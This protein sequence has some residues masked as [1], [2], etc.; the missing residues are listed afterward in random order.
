MK[1]VLA[2]IRMNKMNETKRA[3][4]DAGVACLT[5]RRALG[6]GKGIVDRRVLAGASDGRE[7]AIAQLG[8]APR[9]IPKRAI[10]V[11]VPDEKVET[12]VQTLIKVNQT[13]QPGD[14]KIFVLPVD[15]ALRIRT[16][17]SGDAAL[18]EAGEE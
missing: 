2:M 4:A 16:S 6:R 5:A 17:E 14:G 3:L 9:L 15:D 12:V 11:V 1:E 10:T 13:G 7:E 18:D 8:D